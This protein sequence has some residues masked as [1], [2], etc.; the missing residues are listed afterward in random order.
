MF[1]ID[2]EGATVDNKFTEGDPQLGIPATV[3]SDDWANA[4]QEELLTVVE[5][6]GISPVKGD[7]DQVYKGILEL[8]LRGGRES[9]IVQALANNS[10]DQDVAG[11]NI[12]GA[13]TKTK[14]LLFDIERSTD[15]ETVVQSGVMFL[16]Y[17]NKAGAMK[18][19]SFLSVH[20]FAGVDFNTVLVSGT[21]HKLRYSTNDL[22]G[23]N[24]VGN[25][26]ITSVFEIR[27]S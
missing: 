26:R 8:F 7:V 6:V 20:D 16:T 17:D 18:A 15:S 13:V 23:A 14:I 22:A 9:P 19:P 2:S 25:M 24:Y 21:N 3:V 4:V 27:Q 12:D 1:R 5:S 11:V 10:S